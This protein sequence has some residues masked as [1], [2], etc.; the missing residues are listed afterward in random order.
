MIKIKV[1]SNYSQNQTKC[2]SELENKINIFINEKNI[3][4]EDIIRYET[5]IEQSKVKI[6]LTYWE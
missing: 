4:R 2:F 5:I 3:E 1:F 6:I